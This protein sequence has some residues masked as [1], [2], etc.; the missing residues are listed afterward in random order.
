[1]A[2]ARAQNSHHWV[3]VAE[4]VPAAHSESSVSQARTG[5]REVAEARSSPRLRR[6]RDGLKVRVGVVAEEPVR[7]SS[8]SQ[9]EGVVA[10]AQAAGASCRRNWHAGFRGLLAR[11]V[12]S[13]C[14]SLQ[15][16][17]NV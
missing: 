14:W 16:D 2:A 17:C 10:A 11:P 3:V 4:A 7:Y 15:N 8:Q 1:M 5:S 13:G 6:P 9:L 12:R